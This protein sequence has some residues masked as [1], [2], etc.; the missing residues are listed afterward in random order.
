MP[1]TSPKISIIVP[2]YNVEKYI[3]R[4]LDSIATQTFANWECVLV[5]DGTPDSSGKI[6][7]EYAEKDGRFKVIHKEN[8]GVSSARNAGLDVAKGEYICFCDSDDWLEKDYFFE[9]AGLTAKNP[10]I[11]KSGYRF[12]ENKTVKEE[13]FPCCSTVEEQVSNIHTSCHLV[14]KSYILKHNIR[15]PEGITLAEDW[16]FNYQLALYNPSVVY[17]NR[18]TYNYFQNDYSVMHNLTRKN[19]QDEISVIKMAKNMPEK[20]DEL[21]LL[22]TFDVRSKILNKMQDFA[23]CR[24]TFPETFFEQFKRTTFRGKV[25]IIFLKL[26]FDFPIKFYLSIKNKGNA[27]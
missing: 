5:D 4:C 3:Q 7:D 9:A 19:I 22:R 11:V 27:K 10:D 18:I 25:L 16:F 2:V 26:H 15:F 21:I 12:V 8:G 24:Q 17:L 1:Q 20:N 14:K 23:L 6:C 13:I